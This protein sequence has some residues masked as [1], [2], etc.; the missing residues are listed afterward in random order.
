MNSPVSV[1]WAKINFSMKMSTTLKRK[2]NTEIIWLDPYKLNTN[3]GQILKTRAL[4][5]GYMVISNAHKVMS[6]F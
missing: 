5:N 6:A 4:N 1:F 3:F 2:F